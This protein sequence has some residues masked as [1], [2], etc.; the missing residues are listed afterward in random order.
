MDR[1]DAP[2]C[3]ERIASAQYE[4][5]AT[6]PS[7]AAV[8]TVVEATD[9]DPTAFGPLNAAVDPDALDALVRGSDPSDETVVSFLLDGVEVVVRGRGAVVVRDPSP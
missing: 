1:S 8:E 7:S 5:S 2:D 9:C 3:E 6:R 4:W